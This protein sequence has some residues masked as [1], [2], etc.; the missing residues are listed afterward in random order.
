M[1]PN[2]T[3]QVQIDMSKLPQTLCSCGSQ[4]F[5]QV[6]TAR[7]AS[8]LISPTGKADHIMQV[9][10]VCNECNTP[11]PPVGTAKKVPA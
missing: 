10:W 5:K 3:K 11:L 7:E 4:Y 2:N 1:Q 6:F 8:A 9:V